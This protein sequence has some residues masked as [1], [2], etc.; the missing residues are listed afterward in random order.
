[1]VDGIAEGAADS[2]CHHFMV[3]PFYDT[4]RTKKEN[5]NIFNIG[6]QMDWN[7]LKNYLN[8]LLKYQFR[9]GAKICQK[10]NSQICKN[11]EK[12]PKLNNQI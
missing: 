1:M 2:R 11:F 4:N 7:G 10:Y 3:T 8:Q 9:R 5:N 6:N 12:S